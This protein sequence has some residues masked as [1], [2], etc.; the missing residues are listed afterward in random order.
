MP[1]AQRTII[2]YRSSL[3]GLRRKRDALRKRA[4]LLRGEQHELDK[5]EQLIAHRERVV[6]EADR[7][8]AEQADR[9]A[10][11]DAEFAALD[12]AALQPL[13]DGAEFL[14]LLDAGRQYG[15]LTGGPE[16]DVER[17]EAALRVGARRGL[18]P[19]PAGETAADLLQ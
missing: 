9:L 18:V 7:A 4:P 3:V 14:L 5:L 2:A 11:L 10:T 12:D 1:Y 13:V 16:I 8:A 6:A 19:R 15:L 17:C